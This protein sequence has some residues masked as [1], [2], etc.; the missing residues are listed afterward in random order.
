L[1][2]AQKEPEKPD[3]S[4]LVEPLERDLVLMLAR[5]PEVFVNSAENLK[6]NAIADYAN[7]LA[8][9]FNSFY[10]SLPVIKA[11]PKELSDARLALVEA[12][13]IVL[14]NSLSLIGIVAPEKM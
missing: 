6:P 2:K 14:R 12:I 7:I 3:Y 9:K 1:R 8:D 11:E 5:F 13:S 4:L 10:N